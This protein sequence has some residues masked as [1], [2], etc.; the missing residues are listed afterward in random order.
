MGAKAPRAFLFDSWVVL[1]ALADMIRSA[2]NIVGAVLLLAPAAWADGAAL[3]CNQLLL[4]HQRELLQDEPTLLVVLSP[5]MPYALKEWPRMAAV[6]QQDGWRVQAF[7]DPGVPD[8][9]WLAA[10]ELGDLRSWR[11]LP[12]M[13]LVAGQACGMLNHAPTALVARCG[14]VHPWPIW[15]VMPDAAWRHVLASRRADLEATPC[16]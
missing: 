11:T 3:S 5:R 13:D 7:R 12:V 16:R 14:R 4:A 6:A 15:G 9:E 8:D 2:W 1:G 10:T